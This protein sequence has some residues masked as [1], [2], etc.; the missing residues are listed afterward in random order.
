MYDPGLLSG[1][2]RGKKNALIGFLS[3]LELASN[4]PQLLGIMGDIEPTSST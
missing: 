3:R 1:K 2:G 4:T